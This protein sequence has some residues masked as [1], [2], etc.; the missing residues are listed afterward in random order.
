MQRSKLEK[1]TEIIIGE[2]VSTL[3][4]EDARISGSALASRLRLMAATEQNNDRLEAIRQALTEIESE[5]TSAR[6]VSDAPVFNFN[7]SAPAGSKK[8]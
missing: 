6:N 5:F 3:L 1:L 8:H 7:H 2:A 4:E